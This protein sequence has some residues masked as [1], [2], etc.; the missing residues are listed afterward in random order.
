MPGGVSR[1]VSVRHL[2]DDFALRTMWSILQIWVT[3]M[4]TTVELPDDLLE[5]AKLMA[6]REHSTLKAL[7]EEGLHLALRLRSRSRKPATPFAV[8]PF[9]GNGLTPEF[10]AAG[11]EKIRDEIYRDRG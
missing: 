3:H 8:Q 2:T 4:K 10:T 1:P 6:K 9:K 11:W 5:R 7:I